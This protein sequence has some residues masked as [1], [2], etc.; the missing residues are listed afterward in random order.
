MGQH[1]GAPTAP[2][3]GTTPRGAAAALRAKRIERSDSQTLAKG[4]A[5]SAGR[6]AHC[7]TAGKA[8]PRGC[9]VVLCPRRVPLPVDTGPGNA[10]QGRS[11]PATQLLNGGSAHTQHRCFISSPAPRRSGRWQLAAAG[12]GSPAALV[13]HRGSPGRLCLTLRAFIAAPFPAERKTAAKPPEPCHET[14]PIPGQRL[15]RAQ[16]QPA[17]TGEA[18]PTEILRQLRR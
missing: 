10:S 11:L 1:W 18:K 7:S 8:H 13:K 9:G 2:T 16:S 4:K 5:P 17:P 15:L 3:W 12:R 14:N 6:T